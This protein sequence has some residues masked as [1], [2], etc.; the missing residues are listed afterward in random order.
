MYRLSLV[1]GEEFVNTYINTTDSMTFINTNN[2]K[3]LKK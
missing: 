3:T 2:L 1:A